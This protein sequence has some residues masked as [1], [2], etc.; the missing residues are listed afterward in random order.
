[1]TGVLV[2]VA[3]V[4]VAYFAWLKEWQ[5]LAGAIFGFSG[6]ILTL[7]YNSG[8]ERRPFRARATSE[9]SSAASSRTVSI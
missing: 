4:V 5:T 8:Q 3:S 1:M 7:W 2:D 6:I 9:R